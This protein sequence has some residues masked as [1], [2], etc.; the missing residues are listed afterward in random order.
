MKTLKGIMSRYPGDF[1][2]MAYK[3]GEFFTTGLGFDTKGYMSL[4]SAYMTRQNQKR[5][6]G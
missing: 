3:D 4:L 1:E 6:M 5:A 2:V